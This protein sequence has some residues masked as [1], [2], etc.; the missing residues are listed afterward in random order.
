MHP[1][2]LTQRLMCFLAGFVVAFFAPQRAAGQLPLTSSPYPM[3]DTPLTLP[4]GTV[5]RVRNLIVFQSQ[6]SSS[7]TIYIETPT[8][9][10][11][12]FRLAREARELVELHTQ[13]AN[14]QSLSTVRVAVC[15]SPACVEMRE[16][17]SETY[18]YRRADSTWVSISP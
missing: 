2:R 1:W 8:P 4:S 6:G 16:K 9:A 7:L 15:R 13:F 5:V 3:S 10:A 12:S 18:T 17:P 11:D 14:V